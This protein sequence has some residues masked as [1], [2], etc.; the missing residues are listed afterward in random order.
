LYFSG[1]E[2]KKQEKRAAILSAALAEF[3]GKRF[4][5]VK[6]DGIAARAGVGKGTLYLYFKSKEDL[7]IQ[8][9]LDGVDK[10]VAQIH[11][12]AEMDVP[13][14]DRFF[15]FGRAVGEFVLKR[16]VMFQLMNQIGS[17]EIQKEFM[18]QHKALIRAARGLLQAGVD[19]GILR[20]DVTIADLHCL[21]IGPLLFRVRL[22]H[23]NNDNIEVESLL[24][25]F[26][27]AAATGQGKETAN[28]R[29]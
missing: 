6:L 11:D 14:R 2:K 19:D 16:S 23:F 10:M 17:E 13:F 18:Q 28:E 9:A 3:T 26:W 1:M 15:I 22:N 21:L 5:E 27:S 25:L 8:M 7:F 4:D 24:K 20:N 29:K 12:I